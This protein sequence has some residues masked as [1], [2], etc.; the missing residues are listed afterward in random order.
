MQ[1]SPELCMK[2]LLAAGYDRIFQ[3]CHCWRQGERGTRHLPEFTMLE[4]YRNGTDY[5]GLMEECEGLV[6]A[7]ASALGRGET[8]RYQ[9]HTISLAGP[10][11][12]ISVAEAFLRF[13]DVSMEKALADDSF[14]ELMAAKIEPNLGL[15]TPTFIYD[16]PAQRG[17]LARLKPENP[18]LAER[19]ELY[20]CGIE[21][22][23][24]FSELTDAA[25][26]RQRFAAENSH[27]QREGK[28]AYELPENFLRELDRLNDAAGIA[29]GV[30]RLVMLFHDT[31]DISQV[32]PFTPEEL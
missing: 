32:V 22:A 10:W 16:Y 24:A 12:R 27:R 3:V 1:T 21:L 5:R 15:T 9:G 14:D 11:E 20:I 4:W 29:L 23:N 28:Q 25:E 18:R 30:D 2:R 19:F 17:A 6:G 7:V 31:T 8:L 26:Q 13:C